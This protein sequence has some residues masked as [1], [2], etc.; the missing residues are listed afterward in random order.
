MATNNDLLMNANEETRFKKRY[1]ELSKSLAQRTHFNCDEVEA[2]MLLHYKLTNSQGKLDSDRT[3][4]L[5]HAL[6]DM[7][8]DNILGKLF[9]ALDIS[10][11]QHLAM[12]SWVLGLSTLLRGTIEEKTR[13]CFKSYDFMGM[14]FINKESMLTLLRGCLVKT[15]HDEDMDESVKDLQEMLMK[16]LDRDRDGKISL[17]DF[18]ESVEKEPL[19]MECL[20]QCMPSGRAAKAFLTTFSKKP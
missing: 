7:T 2:L 9:A 10:N 20:G 12:T 4:E 18:S 3:V 5:L 14:G 15:P 6:L 17:K 19:I 11:D 16:K 13:L 8:D 1:T